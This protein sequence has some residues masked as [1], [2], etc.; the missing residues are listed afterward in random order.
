MWRTRIGARCVTLA[1][2]AALLG[3]VIGTLIEQPS[4]RATVVIFG[5]GIVLVVI[6]FLVQQPKES[7][8]P[9]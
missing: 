6:S 4:T 7:D 2:G 5:I 3:V 8:K 9:E 1:V